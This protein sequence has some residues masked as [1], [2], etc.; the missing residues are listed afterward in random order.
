MAFGDLDITKK[1]MNKERS[2][3]TV[4]KIK[5]LERM[6]RVKTNGK[7]KRISFKI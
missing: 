7:G 5:R 6:E 1:Y 3:S 2:R 4:I